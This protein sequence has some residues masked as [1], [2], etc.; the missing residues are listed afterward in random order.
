M[1]TCRILNPLSPR[2]GI[3]H[4]TTF[5]ADSIQDP[6]PLIF[7]DKQIYSKVF[8]KQSDGEHKG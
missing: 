1:P 8:K 2:K 7:I 4:G 6:K 5:Q 3:R